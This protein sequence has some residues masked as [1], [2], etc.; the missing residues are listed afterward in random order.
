MTVVGH[1][2]VRSKFHP[3]NVRFFLMVLELSGRKT[4]V[5]FFSSPDTGPQ[6]EL[7]D[8]SV[9]NGLVLSGSADYDQ[10]RVVS[11]IS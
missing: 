6:E 4:T 8:R 7:E 1:R 11:V 3:K 2:T 5:L 10:L 9:L